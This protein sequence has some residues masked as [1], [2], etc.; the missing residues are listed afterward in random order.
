MKTFEWNEEGMC[1]K[2]L[3]V[4]VL[5]VIFFCS[6]CGRMDTA[7]PEAT[8]PETLDCSSLDV[9]RTKSIR[10]HSGITGEEVWL[11]DPADIQAITDC[12]VQIR[13][14]NPESSRGYYGWTYTI[15]L[16]DTETPAEDA[17]PFWGGSMCCGS[18]GSMYLYETVNGHMYYAR[19][20][21]TGITTEEVDAVCE[22]FFP[23]LTEE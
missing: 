7:A 19:Y 9:A 23:P 8:V 13:A 6:G 15:E 22:V 10:L 11:T 4:A 20:D 1:M 5:C 18:F 16:Y 21:M 14:E 12:V 3:F 17:K 2:R